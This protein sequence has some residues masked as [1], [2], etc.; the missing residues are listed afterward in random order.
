MPSDSPLTLS[1]PHTITPPFARALATRIFFSFALGYFISYALRS[2]NAALA[3]PLDADLH[4]SASELGWLSSAFFLSVA[5][6]QLPV[7]IWLDR[8]DARLADLILYL[9]RCDA[10]CKPV[11]VSD[12]SSHCDTHPGLIPEIL[13]D[14]SICS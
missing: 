13:T 7:G 14:G 2:V 8:D 3:P 10:A 1:V 11:L 5:I 12:A 6:M 9:P 4:L